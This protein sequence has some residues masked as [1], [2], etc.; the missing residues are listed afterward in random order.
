MSM[1]IE[2]ADHAAK[3]EWLVP[4]GYELVDGQLVE[5]PMGAESGRVAGELY[6][7]MAA[8]CDA[9]GIG[10]ALPGDIGFRCFPHRPRLLRKP[11]GSF[12]R[13]ERLV[14][15]RVPTGDIAFPPDLTVEAVS[16]NELAEALEEKVSDYLT[17]GTRL[18]WVIYPILRK[19]VAY[20]PGGGATWIDETG[21]LDGRDVIPGFRCKLRDIL[22]PPDPEASIGEDAPASE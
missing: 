22:Q 8:H 3:E 20:A 7:R 15:G 1:V 18:V 14:N 4:D 9:T 17:A 16:P 21:E 11:D 5:M 13:A 12:L 10:I 2:R 19:A 6:R